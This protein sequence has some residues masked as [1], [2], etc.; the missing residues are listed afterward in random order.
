VVVDVPERSQ[1]FEGHVPGSLSL[2]VH[3]IPLGAAMLPPGPA[4]AVRCGHAYGGTL[5]ASL[6]EQAGHGPI[7]VAEDGYAGWLAHD[8]PC[9]AGSTRPR[10]GAPRSGRLRRG[11]I[12][13]FLTDLV[14]EQAGLR[15]Q[16]FFLGL[17]Y[18]GLG[19]AASTLLVRETRGHAGLEGGTMGQALAALSLRQVLWRTSLRR[20]APVIREPGRPDRAPRGAQSVRLGA[21]QLGTGALSDRLGRKW[22]IVGVYPTL[23]A[24]VGDAAHPA[25]RAS[26]VCV[27]RLWRDS[28][29][30]VGGV[31][32]GV[33]ADLMGPASAIR[34]VAAITAASG[35]VVAIRMYETSPRLRRSG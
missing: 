13:A 27:S 11:A 24:A 6:L 12:T 9:R 8:R 1:W 7:T 23:L 34:V 32:S 15:P 10:H 18:V 14:A 26:A 16:P 35:L 21:V 22:L 25:W 3:E 28:G 17:A 5:G 20:P 4:L 33:V 31:V 29:F 2:P 30:A 19:L